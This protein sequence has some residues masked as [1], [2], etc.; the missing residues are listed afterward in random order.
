MHR[1]RLRSS[2]NAD[3]KQLSEAARMEMLATHDE[4]RPQ[5]FE[6]FSCDVLVRQRG[7]QV[8]NSLLRILDPT[9]TLADK[10]RFEFRL[11]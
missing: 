2:L 5:S 8:R 10:R 4:D 3:L 11:E 1:T 9:V 6:R 7:V